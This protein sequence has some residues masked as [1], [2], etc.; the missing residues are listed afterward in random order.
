VPDPA[1]IWDYNRFAYA[2]LNP[3]KFNDPTG[4]CA[5]LK[6]GSPNWEGQVNY[7]CWQTAYAIYGYGAAGLAA[8]QQ[9]WKVTADD[10]L[11]NIAKQEFATTEYLQPFLN[12][13]NSQFCAQAG[14]SC[15]QYVPNP[16]PAQSAHSSIDGFALGVGFGGSYAIISLG[17]GMEVVVSLETGE[18]ALVTYYSGGGGVGAGANA[19]AYAAILIN[20]SRPEDYA[21]PTNGVEGTVS[22]PLFGIVGGRF[23]S[24]TP[25]GTSGWYLGY[26]PG[27]RLSASSSRTSYTLPWIK[28]DL[29]AN[30][31]SFPQV[32]QIIQQIFGDSDK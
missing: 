23:W 25:N 4:H 14:L 6:D 3:M 12:K 21:G 30:Q 10:W 26:A 8:F 13:Y 11:E 15:G 29:S 27:A 28:Y 32:T 20:M 16:P 1:N 5:T 2:R 17:G 22:T 19:K 18:I 9:D 24:A 7:Q 31:I